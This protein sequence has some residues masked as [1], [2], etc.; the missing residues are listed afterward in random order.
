MYSL[1]KINF[2]LKLKLIFAFFLLLFVNRICA[3]TNS[4]RINAVLDAKNDVLKIQQELVYHNNS[5]QS[6]SEIYLLNWANSFKDKNT[7]LTKRLIEDYDKSLYFA[8]EN[9]RG[10]SKILNL[11]VNYK[12][13]P[14]TSDKNTEDILK[15]DLAEALNPADSI[16]ISA[17]FTV[18]IPDAKFTGYGKTKTGYHLRYW[19]LT[20][21]VF[22]TD[23][24]LMSNLNID[25]LFIDI[26]NYDIHLKVAENTFVTSNLSQKKE[27]NSVYTLSGKNKTDV[28][29][30]IDKKNNFTVYK[31]E[32]IDVF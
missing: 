18:K 26:T 8:K 7:P 24:Q 23:W 15:I 19:Y 11:S 20:P 2:V 31:T 21:V 17:S 16:V 5:N 32:N 3:Q 29:I 14:F 28:I 1:L 9:E 13:T 4:I 25:D 30:S 10:F 27:S 12:P 6:L 22:T